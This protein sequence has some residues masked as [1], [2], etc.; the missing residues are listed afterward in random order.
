M[1]NNLSEGIQARPLP[2]PVEMADI[3]YRHL[4]LDMQR[5]FDADGPWPTPWMHKVL[6]AI[7]ELTAT[8][9]ART[10]FTRFITP[11]SPEDVGGMWKAYY[12]KWR[13]VTLDRLDPAMLELVGELQQFVPPAEIFDKYTFPLSQTAGFIAFFSWTLS[14]L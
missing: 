8:A 6:P 1:P 7:V 3:R 11:P 5:L 10:M 2:G 12:R 4:C 14:I 13:D 9:P